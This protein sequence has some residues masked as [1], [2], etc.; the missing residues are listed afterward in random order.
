[1][2]KLVLALLIAISL[3]LTA[4]SQ[5]WQQE[6]NYTIDVSLNDKDHSIDAFERIE[7][8]NKSPD[9]LHFI[10]FHLWPNAYKNDKTA[11]SDQDLEN[12]NT[13]F[14]FSNRENKGYINKL[15]FK[16]NNVTALLED[17][18][19]HIDIVKLVLPGP[20]LPGQKVSITTPFHVKLPFN[21]SRMGHDGESYQLTQ[22]YPKPAVYDS[23]GWH[24][25]PYLDQGEFYSEFGSFEVSIT[26]PRNYVVAATGELQNPTE[27]NWMKSRS[28]FNWEPI[29]TK[30]KLKGGIIKTSTQLF[31]A[32]DRES[33]TLV[34]KL[35][36][37]H[38]FAWFAD[39]RFIVNFD[40]CKLASG[41]IIN[42][43]TYYTT[44]NKKSWKR[45][46]QFCK[47][48]VRHYSALVG[49]YPYPVVSAV[50]GPQSFGGGMEYPT[51]TVISPT[52]DEKE[53]DGTIAHELGHNWFYGIL[54]SN[55]R[56]HPWMDEGIN[57]YYDHKYMRSKYPPEPQLESLYFEYK[58]INHT[59]QPIET[60]AEKFGVV[61]YELVAYHKTGVW[62]NW[63][64]SVLGTEACNK[65]MQDYYRRWQFRHPQPE[66]FRASIEES[67]GKKLDS[68]FS[69]LN[70]PGLLP[71]QYRSGTK[72]VFALNVKPIQ[73]YLVHPYKELYLIGPALGTNSYDKFMLGAFFTNYKMPVSRLSFFVAP[74][75]SFGA[76]RLAGL[77]T[78]RF[79]SY[80]GFGW[81]R[82]IDVFFNGSGFAYD[83][84][85][86]L[87]KKKKYFSFSKAS[88]GFRFTAKEKDP[89]S[90]ALKYLQAKTYIISEE[91]F[92]QITYDT[93][94]SVI[95]QHVP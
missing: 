77:G 87:N 59:D 25:M 22:W 2:K 91:T 72:F 12:G 83:E 62:M 52:N 65:A 21:Y 79:S 53:L 34:Y 68:V 3:Q 75:Y 18:P 40:T 13:R 19:Q 88:F 71:N 93:V 11:Y 14:Y 51:I 36:K 56:D 82:K 31:P 32:S 70:K 8:I 58:A 42:V 15:D 54:A 44:A 4:F 17:H 90:N 28:S 1:M 89:R 27:L 63:L 80:Q 5:Y 30:E 10:W 95:T 45:S 38:D 55:E 29:K 39:K 67:S 60:P 33:K 37:I 26:V 61:N 81:V 24:P 9:T 49:E 7:Y 41:K 6:V 73:E 48:A 69:L 94:G 23:K 35:D 86:M 43:Y 57:T 47:D 84:F 76:K 66:D 50:Q 16:V 46:I 92:G 74:M 20:L 64:E 78:L 85:L